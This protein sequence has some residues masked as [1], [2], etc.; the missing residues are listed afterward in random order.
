MRPD[1]DQNFRTISSESVIQINWHHWRHARG[2]VASYVEAEDEDLWIKGTA[3]FQ[4]L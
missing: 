1:S 4:L 2:A 3:P